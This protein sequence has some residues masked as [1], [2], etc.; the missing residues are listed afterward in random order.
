MAKT[1]IFIK[2]FV[3]LKSIVLFDMHDS[4]VKMLAIYASRSKD[5]VEIPKAWP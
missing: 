5:I 1:W 3:N 4:Q 2:K